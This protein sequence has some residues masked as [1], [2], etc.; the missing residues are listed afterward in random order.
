MHGVQVGSR[1]C[2]KLDE[3]VEAGKFDA[4]KAD[5]LRNGVMRGFD[6]GLDE[7]QLK[8]KRVFKNYPTAYSEK[9]KVSDALRDRVRTHKTLNP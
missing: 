8:G 3:L 2:S 1:F 9:D 7:N 5:Y 4:S 6:L